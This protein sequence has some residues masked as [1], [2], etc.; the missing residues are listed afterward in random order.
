MSLL[1][2][3]KQRITWSI[4]K[5]DNT[6]RFWKGNWILRV[7]MYLFSWRKT[8]VLCIISIIS[9]KSLSKL[10][11][12]NCL[13]FIC[14]Q[15]YTNVLRNRV[16]YQTQVTTLLPCLL[17]ILHLLLQLS[18]IMLWSTVKLLLAIVMSII[19]G[20]LKTLPR[21]SKSCDY[22]TFR[23]LSIFFRLF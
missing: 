8:N 18:K 9:P 7:Q 21:S 11:N 3:I 2:P 14:C 16:L 12:K 20:P 23:V 17:S 6:W 1:L 15:N 22:V 10:I 4:L 5:N 19:F 13:H